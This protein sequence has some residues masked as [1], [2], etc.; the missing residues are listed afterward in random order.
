MKRTITMWA[1]FSPTKRIIGETIS[2]KCSSAIWAIENLMWGL[3][4]P[5]LL[6]QGYRC[7]KVQ[8]SWEE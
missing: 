2:P 4:Y 6:K 5:E 7:R 1:V 8:I 3:K